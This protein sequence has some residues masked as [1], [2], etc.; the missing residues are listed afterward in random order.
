[1]DSPEILRVDEHPAARLTVNAAHRA[2]R[3]DVIDGR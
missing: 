3:E 2:H 1:M